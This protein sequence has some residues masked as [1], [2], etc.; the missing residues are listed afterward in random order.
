M[1]E[2]RCGLGLTEWDG[3]LVIAR[4]LLARSRRHLGKRDSRSGPG[5]SRFQEA[6]V[7]RCRAATDLRDHCFNICSETPPNEVLS[8]R[9]ITDNRHPGFNSGFVRLDDELA[10]AVEP[11]RIPLRTDPLSQPRV[12]PRDKGL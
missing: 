9:P 5:I 3:L 8:E 2:T 4:R 11:D 10:N 12:Q 1:R 7:D 6:K